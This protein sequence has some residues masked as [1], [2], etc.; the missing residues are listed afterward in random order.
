MKIQ[1]MMSTAG[2]D[3]TAIMECEHCGATQELKTGYNDGYYHSRVIPAMTCKACGKN[4]SGVVPEERN[5][6]GQRSV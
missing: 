4:R 6:D 5:D 1:K 2:N 3:F